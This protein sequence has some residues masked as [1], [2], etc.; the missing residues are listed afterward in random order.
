MSFF[1]MPDPRRPAP[2][3]RPVRPGAVRRRGG[4]ARGNHR[5]AAAADP[6]TAGDAQIL[7]TA[8]GAE[9]EAI[10]AY[11][12]GAESKLLQK[13]ALDLALASRAITRSMPTCSRRRSRSSAASP[14]PRRRSTTSRSRS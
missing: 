1:S 7:N 8:L 13:P 10:A 11:Q 6:A 2:F 9:L 5:L 3:P 12:L 14:S 4:A